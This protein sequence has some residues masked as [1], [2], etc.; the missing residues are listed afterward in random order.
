MP[1]HFE[2]NGG[3]CTLH[4]PTGSLGNVEEA[5]EERSNLYNNNTQAILP[6][7]PQD[8]FDEAIP[9]QYTE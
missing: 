7:K 5:N 2:D 9:E 8:A 6:E 3:Y 4:T 1:K